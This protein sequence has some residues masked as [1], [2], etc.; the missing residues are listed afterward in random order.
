MVSKYKNRYQIEVSHLYRCSTRTQTL[1]L[2]TARQLRRRR[3]H[4]HK[5][6]LCKRQNYCDVR[7]DSGNIRHCGEPY[8]VTSN[9]C[10]RLRTQRQLLAN[11]TSPPDPQSET[12]TLATH[13]GK[14][15]TKIY[16][17]ICMQKPCSEP[18]YLAQ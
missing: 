6:L 8:G 15:N 17:E 7:D 9:S 3:S 4:T 2:Q 11:V 1:P 10:G 12:G 14:K 18:W 5:H 16:G 13:S